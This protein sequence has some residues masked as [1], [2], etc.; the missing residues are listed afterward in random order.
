MRKFAQVA[1]FSLASVVAGAALAFDNG[2]YNDVP[3]DIR[4]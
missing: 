2:Q 3:A 1:L 4:A